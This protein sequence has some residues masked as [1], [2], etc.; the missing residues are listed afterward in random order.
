MFGNYGCALRR[1]LAAAVGWF[2]GGLHIVCGIQMFF[3]ILAGKQAAAPVKVSDSFE[4]GGSG[5]LNGS[6]CFF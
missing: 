5:R 1:M 6:N 4:E 2:W 3:R